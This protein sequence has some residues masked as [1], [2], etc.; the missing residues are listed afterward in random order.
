MLT[1]SSWKGI[2]FAA[3]PV[4]SLRF[5][6]PQDL[7]AQSSDVCVVG[8]CPHTDGRSQDVS[9]DAL[10]CVQFDYGNYAGNVIGVKRGPG[11]EDVRDALSASLI[12]QCLRLWIWAPANATSS[13]K[14]PVHYYVRPLGLAAT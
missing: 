7:E 1:P 5:R 14:L 13:S 2:R 12:A 4:G 3:P 6:A 9:D 10:R 11:V 8:R